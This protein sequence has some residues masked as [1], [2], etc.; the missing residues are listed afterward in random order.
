MIQSFFIFLDDALNREYMDFLDDSSLSKQYASSDCPGVK[1]LQDKFS[2]N[3][4]NQLLRDQHIV[5]WKGCL[6]QYAR[7]ASKYLDLSEYT[8][9]L[10]C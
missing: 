6:K 1:R 5:T 2:I 3:A 4:I 7:N 8:Q 10:L 9:W